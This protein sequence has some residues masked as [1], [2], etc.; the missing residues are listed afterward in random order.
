LLDDLVDEIVWKKVT[1]WLWIL[2]GRI[3]LFVV[4]SFMK[5]E[6]TIGKGQSWRPFY[7]I[8]TGVAS[9]YQMTFE[10]KNKSTPA[11][12]AYGTIIL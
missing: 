7:I 8:Q 11:I 5:E 9:Q 1:V 2:K 6:F 10:A 4:P 3:M 12:R